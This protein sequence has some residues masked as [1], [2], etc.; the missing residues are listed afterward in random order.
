MKSGDRIKMSKR[1]T[2][3]QLPKDLI[4]LFSKRGNTTVNPM[5]M[6]M[7]MNYMA[8]TL[9]NQVSIGSCDRDCKNFIV[10]VLIVMVSII[11]SF[12]AGTPHKIIILRY[13]GNTDIFVIKS[14]VCS[15]L[16]I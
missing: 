16:F 15:H 9:Y 6:Q 4:K 13:S 1:K 8:R 11:F 12:L 7:Q 3:I 2:N 10:F 14:F 5:V